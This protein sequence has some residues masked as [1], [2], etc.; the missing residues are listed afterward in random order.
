MTD[1]ESALL[2]GPV[3]RPAYDYLRARGIEFSAAFCS[4]P[5]CSPSRASLLTGLTPHHAGVLTNVDAGSMGNP[6]SATLNTIGRT[7]RNAGYKTGYFGKWHL[8]DESGPLDEFGFGTYV[9]GKDEA[10]SQAAAA[11][12]RDQSGPWL[13]WISV[14]N[15]HDIYN[16]TSSRSMPV[17][18]GVR[19]PATVGSDL[20]SRPQPQS[21]YMTEDQG[22]PM[23][24]Y[25]ME[26]WLRY[27]SFYCTLVE[28]AD[29]CLGTVLAA[30]RDPE[31]AITV[32]TSD[33]GD[34]LGEHGLPFKGPFMY[35]PLIRIPLV[36]AGP[37]LKTG[38]THT[39]FATSADLAPTLA[40]LAGL[41]WSG[42]VDGR[43]LFKSAARDAV[44]LEYFGKQH[45][46]APIRTIRTKRWKLNS[47][48]GGETE[49]YD[50]EKD[51][52]EMRNLAGVKSVEKQERDL[53]ARLDRWW[54]G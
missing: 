27:R 40:D 16:I 6:L 38:S 12:I 49:L 4:T 33:H 19:L 24:G 29:A 48:R 39:G 45:W 8:G 47:Y 32:Y 10:V 26:D 37:G 9:R 11:W 36:I 18:P 50:M 22:E 2:P 3:N 23:L 21:R 52:V 54:N 30:V 20:G 41:E 15:P 13:A 31:Q 1:Q 34:T 46:A 51:P 43:D 17:R 14:L 28:K 25:T 42:P 35:E 53:K 5:Q 44:F 7:F